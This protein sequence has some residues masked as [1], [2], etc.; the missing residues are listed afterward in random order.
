MKTMYWIQGLAST[1]SLFYWLYVSAYTYI[2]K[3]KFSSSY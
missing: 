3:L 1:C 2:I